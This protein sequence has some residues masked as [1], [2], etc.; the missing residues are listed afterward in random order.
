MGVRSLQT[1]QVENEVK[2]INLALLVVSN[3]NL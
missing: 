2:L 3:P 1:M